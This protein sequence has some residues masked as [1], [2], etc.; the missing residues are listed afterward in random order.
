MIDFD[1]QRC[2][3]RCAKT[4][5]EFQPGEE[6]YSVL[7]AEGSESVRRDYCAEAWEGPPE[8]A[9]GWWKCQM[10]EAN[11]KKKHMAPNDVLLDYF[12]R[13]EGLPDK[14]DVR[15]VMALLMIRRRI[16][17]LEDTERDD[18]DREIMILFCPRNETEYR[19]HSV[20]LTE[21]RANEIQDELVALLY[22][23]GGNVA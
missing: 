5:R 20:L 15:Y 12:Q 13:L 21:A 14:Q 9:I 4:E 6:F 1:V 17:R 22:T 18:A 10:P 19:V 7:M 16:L 2:S 3:R 11:A 8:D 23:D